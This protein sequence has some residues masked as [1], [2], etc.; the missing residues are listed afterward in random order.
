M[1]QIKQGLTIHLYV[2]EAVLANLRWAIM[3]R[4]YREAIFWAI[5]LYESNML[6]TEFLL[7][8]WIQ[9]TG[10]TK[11]GISILKDILAMKELE[12]GEFIYSIYKWCHL[13]IMDTTCFQLLIRG[14]LTPYNWTIQFPHLV[15]FKDIEHAVYNCLTRKKL[16]EAWIIARALDSDAVWLIIDRF[17]EKAELI[18]LIKSLEVSDYLKRVA[19]FVLITLSNEAIHAA[20]SEPEMRDFPDE[21]IDLIDEL[22]NEESIKKR[23]RFK[24]RPEALTYICARSCMPVSD[25]NMD[26]IQDNLEQNLHSSPCWQVILEDY[27]VQGQWKSE[28]LREAFYN[29][30]FPYI[31]DDI[32]D[33]WSLA[34]KEKSHGRGLG[35]TDETAI[36][37]YINNII[38]YK[39]IWLHDSYEPLTDTLPKSLDWDS[40]YSELQGPCLENLQSNLPFKP[41][42]KRFEIS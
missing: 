3:G 33:E 27:Q 23:R 34:E 18:S 25:S 26:E 32:P 7:E 16:S 17:S 40:V 42:I 31:D 36:R 30:Y 5:E 14:S 2:W 9:Q 8:V 4:N 29:T 6:D 21:L 20:L 1:K 12:R 41:I 24:I 10:F 13:E 15:E 35:K 28:S 38:R 22:D 19:C 11:H 37:Q 39:S